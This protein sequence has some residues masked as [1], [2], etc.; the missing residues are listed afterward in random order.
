MWGKK[1]VY[2]INRKLI[3]KRDLN[4]TMSTIILN[5]RACC[6]FSHVWFCVTLWTVAWKAS[7]SIHRILPARILEWISIPSSRDLGIKPKFRMSPALAVRFFSTSTTWEAHIKYKHSAY[8][9]VIIKLVKQSNAQLYTL[10]KNHILILKTQ[11]I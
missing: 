9:S 7:L 11:M 6:L 5:M 10:T 3:A 2:E 8:K 4:S 1:K